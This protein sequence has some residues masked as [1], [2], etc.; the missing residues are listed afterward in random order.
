MLIQPNADFTGRFL[1]IV[2]AARS[3]AGAVPPAWPLE[4]TVAVNPFLGQ[5]GEDLAAAASRLGRAGGVPVTMP[6]SWYREKVEKGEIATPDLASALL[7]AGSDVGPDELRSLLDREVKSPRGIPTVAMLAAEVSG[8][9]WPEI[10][11]DRV[12]LWAAG[13]FDRGQAA[14]PARSGRGAYGDWR[15]FGS[16]DLTPEIQGLS[17]YARL[18]ANAPDQAWSA[19]ARAAEQLGL[20]PE[21]APGYFHAL[22]LDLGGWAQVARWL[23]WQAELSGDGDDTLTDLLAVR[24]LWEEAL[25]LQYE[26]AIRPAWVAA[27][28]DHAMPLEPTGGQ[29]IDAILQLAAE[30]AAQRGLLANLSSPIRPVGV[31]ARPDLQAVFCIDVRSEVFRRA[32]EAEA[33]GIETIGFAGFFGLPIL[34]RVFGSSEEAAHLPVL[35]QPAVRTEPASDA[36]S[37]AT[38]RV[39]ARAVRA[40]GRFRQAA[41]S[42]FAF[43]EA[44]GPLYAGKLIR[45]SLRFGHVGTSPEPAPVFVDL[46]MA[47]RITAARHVLR[48]MSLTAGFAPVVVLVGHGASTA[49]NP[50]A[51]ALHCGACG[52]QTGAVSARAIAGLLNQKEIREGLAVEGI[53]IPSDTRFVGALHDTTLDEVTLFDLRGAELPAARA[54]LERAGRTARMERAASL[55][56]AGD[57]TGIAVRARDWAQTRPEWGLA[58]CSAFIAAPRHRT[59]GRNLGGRTFLHSYDWRAD[60]GFKTLE[61]ILTAPVVVAS[62]ISLQ[63][64]GSVVAPE[65]FG[66]G[67]KLL[68]NVVGGFGVIEGNGGRLRVGLARQSVHDGAELRH[69]P[70]RL[71]VLVEAPAKAITAILDRH[72]GVRELFDNGWLHLFAME[73]PENIFRRGRDGVWVPAGAVASFEE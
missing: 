14:W 54:W 60:S 4:A 29:R 13:F 34:H 35:L 19:I 1:E 22:L 64:Y 7:A 52:G 33:P 5:A 8:I 65:A 69:D 23:L 50:Q 38:M 45:D 46:S 48:A 40:W 18:V 59:S 62:W 25:F 55:P 26:A 28:A 72:P 67:N 32:L 24:I 12:G 56:G 58:G 42:S 53:D 51:S 39:A 21:A 20:G 10:I 73:E 6:R 36:A 61:L 11:A 44:A 43:V 37:E 47:A 3:A 66:S 31:L 63:Y 17:G 49:N 41:V 68:H 27:C 2:A 71:S 57:G 70:L 15:V 16:H 30:H 9:D